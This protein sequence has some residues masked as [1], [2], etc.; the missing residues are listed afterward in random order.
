M[1]SMKSMKPITAA[2]LGLT[3]AQQ[4][5]FIDGANTIYG[6]SYPN[7]QANTSIQNVAVPTRGQA[8]AKRSKISHEQPSSDGQA[9]LG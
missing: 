5:E 1:K 4:Q 9:N 7:D 6:N 8:P 3:A 2:Q